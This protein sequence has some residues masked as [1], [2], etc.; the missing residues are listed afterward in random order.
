MTSHSVVHLS[1]AGVSLLLD[2]GGARL[3]AVLHWGASLGDIDGR[4]AAALA[5]GAVEPVVPNAIDVPVRLSVLPEPWTG[6]MGKPGLEG[7]R[8]GAGW[9]PH[10]V[11]SGGALDGAPIAGGFVAS[12]PGIVTVDAHDPDADLDVALSIELTPSGV[13][14]LGAEVVNVGAGDYDVSA[15]QLALPVPPIAREVLD[16]A[17]RW[18]KER[19]PQ[20]RPLVVGI[21]EREGR[22]GRTGADAATLLTLGVPGFGFGSGE[23]WGVHVGFSGNHRHYAERLSSGVQVIGGG[24]LL[25]PGEIRLAPGEGYRMPPLYAV[26]GDGLDDQA[27]RLH[28]LLR[29]RPHH[30]GRPRPVTLNVWEA[31][32]FDHDMPRLLDLAERAAGLGVERFVLDDG[33]FRGRRDDTAGLGD[34]FVDETV[35]TG[36]LRPLADRVRALGMEFGLWFEPEMVNPDSDLAREHPEWILSTGERLPVLA[37]NQLVLDLAH[38]DAY[39]YLLERLS[40]VV[41]DSDVA[42]VKWDHNRDLVDAG[43]GRRRVAGVHRQTLA[44]YRLMDDLRARF[45]GL[46]IESCSSGGS[47]VDL[48]ILEHTDRVWVSDCIDPLERQD[49]NRWTTQLLP[50]ELLGSHIA[51]GESHTTGRRHTLSFRAATALTAHLGVEWD[52]A[53]ATTEEL[54]ELGEWIAFHKAHRELFHTG[55]MVRVDTSDPTLRL[56]GTVSADRE[57]AAFVLATV[58]RSEVSP[59]GRFVFRGLDE[60]RRYAVVPVHPGGRPRGFTP[61][62]WFGAETADGY[63]GVELSG[64]ALMT[65]GLHTPAMFPESAVVFQVTAV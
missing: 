20:R 34:W 18:G 16:F 10:F 63:A 17:G 7:H 55:D 62:P 22:R 8:S 26:Y 1:A 38:P 37:R 43:T 24:E 49:M 50:P 25:L 32:Y 3:P 61:A 65:A 14:R 12:G 60:S 9:S 59:R 53:R 45:P 15:L 47:R 2:V 4:D 52:L 33:W 58:G 21:E 44:A 19:I 40:A 28:A 6:W 42:Y 54:A 11:A 30:P 35:W 29:A 41:S 57:R 39:A 46:E 56:S 36:G 13:V 23:V 51:S 48:G 31:V 64:R 27:R 5:T